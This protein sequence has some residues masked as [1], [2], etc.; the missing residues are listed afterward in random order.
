MRPW[1]FKDQKPLVVLLYPDISNFTFQNVKVLE[2]KIFLIDFLNELDNFKK[3]IFYTPKCKLI[4]LKNFLHKELLP[5]IE[6]LFC[7]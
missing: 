1:A 4:A 6:I 5:K 7:D 3:K 2:C